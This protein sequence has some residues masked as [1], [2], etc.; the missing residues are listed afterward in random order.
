MDFLIGRWTRDHKDLDLIAFTTDR[1]RLQAELATLDIRLDYDG[2]WNTH[3]NFETDGARH[4]GLE[5]VFLEPAEPKS[6][7]LVITADNPAGAPAGR[8]G[9]IPD[10]LDPAR[11]ATLDGV[12]FRV[13]SAASE[14]WSRHSS[15]TLIPGRTLEPKIAHDLALLETLVP[16]KLRTVLEQI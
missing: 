3:W 6:G 13:C 16:K 4:T 5:I 8:Y 14:W 15:A 7:I 9:L 12:A 10:A 11:V 2:G 1:A